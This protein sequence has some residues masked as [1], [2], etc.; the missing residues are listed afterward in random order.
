MQ[1]HRHHG[2]CLRAHRLRESQCQHEPGVLVVGGYGP[3][4]C[5]IPIERRGRRMLRRGHVEVRRSDREGR[6]P[7]AGLGLHFRQHHAVGAARHAQ[8]RQRI[9]LHDLDAQRGPRTGAGLEGHGVSFVIRIGTAR[10]DEPVS[11]STGGG[12]VAAI[13]G[14]VVHFLVV[15]DLQHRAVR[16]LGR[17]RPLGVPGQVPAFVSR[18]ELLFPFRSPRGHGF[19][20]GRQPRLRSREPGLDL[21]PPFFLLG[22]GQVQLR[23]PCVLSAIGHQ[24]GLFDVSEERLHGVEIAGGERVE[25]MVVALGAS[26][27]AAHPDGHGGAHAVGGILRQVLFGLQAAFRGGAVQAVVGRGHALLGSGIGDQIAGQ[28]FA[29]ELV[30]RLIIAK[31]VQDIIAIRPR[32]EGVIAVEPAGVGVADGVQPV[33]TLLFGILRRRH[34]AVHQ[35]FIGAGGCVLEERGSI[36]GSG[37]QTRQVE[38]HAADQRAAI[39]LGRGVQSFTRQALLEERVNRIQGGV[40]RRKALHR[41]VGPVAF[42][43]RAF[44]HPLADS[45][46]LRGGQVLMDVRWRHGA[47]TAGEDALD[48]G[49]LLRIAGNDGRLP[50]RQMFERFVADIEPHPRHAGTLVRPVAPEA[51]LRHDRPDIAVEADLRRGR[52]RGQDDRCASQQARVSRWQSLLHG[53]N[54]V[55][56]RRCTTGILACVGLLC[57]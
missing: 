52:R 5:W 25:L 17:N 10:D 26:H 36:F 56:T 13:V 24:P 30:E 7:P 20:L 12:Q 55:Y 2:P 14:G 54:A 42:V 18:Q 4:R 3:A 45:L 39:G 23:T 47:R 50:V 1:P 31:C 41:L 9:V 34:Q 27:R 33:H 57:C 48:D 46:L 28:L 53:L 51:S 11:G 49:A 29:S 35:L 22:R 19:H 32:G 38:R 21:F 15:V 40:R 43:L 16:G 8:A 44:R 37:R 6:L